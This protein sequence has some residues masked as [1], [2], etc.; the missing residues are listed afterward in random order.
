VERFLEDQLK[1]ERDGF[2]CDPRELRGED[3]AEY[4]R[5][6]VLALVDEAHEALHEVPGWKPWKES[7]DIGTLAGTTEGQLF[8]EELVDCLHFI[9]NLL[10]AAGVDDEEL[11]QLY[12]Q[13]RRVNF[14][15]QGVTP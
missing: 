6:N 14:E 1:L 2:G 5:W 9:G 13:K 4:V 8:A 15:R 10:L 11:A 3:L 12:E 7:A